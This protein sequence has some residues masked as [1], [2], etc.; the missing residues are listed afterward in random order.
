MPAWRPGGRRA[1]AR[2]DRPGAHRRPSGGNRAR[3][4]PRAPAA[5]AGGRRDRKDMPG[6]WGRG[7]PAR[8]PLP[9]GQRSG[10]AAPPHLKARPRPPALPGKWA[11]PPS[12]PPRPSRPRSA[13]GAQTRPAAKTPGLPGL[14]DPCGW[15]SNP[16]RGPWGWGA[17]GVQAFG[18]PGVRAP[19][20][21][22]SE[23]QR[24]WAPASASIETAKSSR[25]S[26][27]SQPV[28]SPSPPCAPFSSP[29]WEPEG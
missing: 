23:F 26:S 14:G 7:G 18:T 8:R 10:A 3:A 20:K 25:P 19:A 2:G 29:A 4:R 24:P 22:M 13:F 16:V 21:F 12:A 6:A 5:Q 28:C 15:C 1:A 17:T 27:S 11:V 9:P